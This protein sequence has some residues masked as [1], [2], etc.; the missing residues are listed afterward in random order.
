MTKSKTKE[1]T[2]LLY[3]AAN[4]KLKAIFQKHL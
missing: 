4:K 2:I 1:E 3:D